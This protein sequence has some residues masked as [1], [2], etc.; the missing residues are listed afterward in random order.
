MQER[1]VFIQHFGNEINTLGM[2]RMKDQNDV[3]TLR[4]DYG[5]Y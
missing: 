1:Y 2:Q 5:I 4:E 3:K